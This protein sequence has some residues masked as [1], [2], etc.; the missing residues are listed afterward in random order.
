MKTIVALLFVAASA[1]WPVIVA[2]GDP[3]PQKTGKPI[4]VYKSPTCSCCAAWADY[5]QGHGFDVTAVDR[6][7]LGGIKAQYGVWRE[8]QSCHTAVVDGYAIEGHV[9]ADDIWRLLTEKPKAAGL[10]APGMPMM[11]P[12]MHSI[13]PRGYD[14]L[15]FGQDD[16]PT[17]YSRY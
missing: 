7:D 17:V 12:G 10:T 16:G 11:S 14:V 5:L 1:G 6:R 13:E 9:P 8:L 3:P 2:A 15:L 4:T